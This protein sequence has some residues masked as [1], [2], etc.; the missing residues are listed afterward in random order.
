[1]AHQQRFPIT[2]NSNI[3]STRRAITHCW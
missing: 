1:M 2:A 3:T